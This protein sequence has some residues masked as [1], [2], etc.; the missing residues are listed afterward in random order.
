[1]IVA[2]PRN[3]STRRNSSSW[4]LSLW[5]HTLPR[6]QWI[7]HLKWCDRLLDNIGIA[8]TSSTGICVMAWHLRWIATKWYLIGNQS[9]RA[10]KCHKNNSSEM[11]RQAIGLKCYLSSFVEQS[12]VQRLNCLL[13]LTF[14]Q[15]N[16]SALSSMMLNT[17]LDDVTSLMCHTH[18][19]TFVACKGVIISFWLW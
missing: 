5:A 2:C 17:Q 11:M 4:K 18:T 6:I 14:Y 3:P 12:S 8:I 9:S 13:A 16:A 10:Q 15:R 19:S 1:M 7:I